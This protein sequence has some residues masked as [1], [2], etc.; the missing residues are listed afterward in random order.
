MDLY[1]PVFNQYVN[2]Y[3]PNL[4]TEYQPTDLYDAKDYLKDKS[5]WK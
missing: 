1:L 2:A 3:A 5:R 4:F